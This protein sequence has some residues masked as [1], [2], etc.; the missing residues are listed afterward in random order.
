M[1]APAG[2]LAV[3]NNLKIPLAVAAAL[4]IFGERADLLRLAL[5]GGLML[6]AAALAARRGTEADARPPRSAAG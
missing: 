6:I 4:T 5:G 2:A 1:T 3:F